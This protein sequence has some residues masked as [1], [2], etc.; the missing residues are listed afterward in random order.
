MISQ[1][2]DSVS[3]AANLFDLSLVQ[4]Q[5]VKFTINTE[6][7]LPIKLISKSSYINTVYK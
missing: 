2:A 3:F 7:L 5:V 4:F 1:R 6:I